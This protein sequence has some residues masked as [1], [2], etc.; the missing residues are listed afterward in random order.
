MGKL[1]W[2]D[3]TT[4]T[5][6]KTLYE[7]ALQGEKAENGFKQKAWIAAR[8]AL[9]DSHDIELETTPLKSKWS[10]EAGSKKYREVEDEEKEDEVEDDIVET[11]QWEGSRRGIRREQKSAGMAIAQA[12]DR[13]GTTAQSIQQ[14]KTELAIEKLQA[15]Y[16]STLSAEDM[17]KGLRL[18]ESEVKAS[19][20]IALQG[21]VARDIWLAETLN[22]M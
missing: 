6:L 5:L 22:Q 4:Q 18:M 9:K 10:N 21:G 20:F 15:E 2:S 14:S 12:L 13:I 11:K 17:V 16:G 7:Q 1:K 3:S 8:V 19:V